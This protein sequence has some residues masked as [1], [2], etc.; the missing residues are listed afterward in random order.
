[1]CADAGT[2]APRPVPPIVKLCI[3]RR[4]AKSRGQTTHDRMPE[5]I[6]AAVIDRLPTYY[7]YLTQLAEAG[8]RETSSQE[9]GE[10]LDWTPAQVRR[11]FSHLGRLGKQGSG[12]RIDRL[13]GE[14]RET[15]G[16]NRRWRMMLVGAGVLGRIVASSG[17]EGLHL[18]GFD[19]ARVYAD[20]ERHVGAVIGGLTAVDW[21][22][23]EADQRDDPVRVAVLATSGARAQAVTERLAA[24][25]VYAILNY[26]STALRPP[27]GVEVRDVN[28]VL[29]LQTMTYH[30]ANRSA[31]GA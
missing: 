9:V 18:S 12:Y 22:S 20:Q 19:L 16:L 25:G 30:V 15:L 7:R 8:E 28:P 3:I 6:P 23:L 14:L 10:A 4:R 17:A 1:M 31:D 24:A 11:D 13:L 5:D 29:A 26:A 21:S 2:P 27:P